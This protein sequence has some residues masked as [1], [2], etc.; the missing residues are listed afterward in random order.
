VENSSVNKKDVV[1]EI[2][3]GTGVIT[4]EL[5]NQ[6]KSVTAFEFDKNLYR[7]LSLKF[8]GEKNL[9]LIN[10]DFLAYSLPS[11]SYKVFSNIPFNLTSAIIK[12]LIF[13]ENSPADSYLIVQKEAAI[14]FVGKPYSK[15]NSQVAVLGKPWFEFNIIHRFNRADFSPRPSVDTVLLRIEKRGQP[16]L[17]HRLKEQYQDFVVYVFS[18]FKPN[19]VEGLSPL[20]NRKP[21]LQI[22]DRLSISTN[23]KPS[24][25]EYKGWLDIFEEFQKLSAIKKSK[26]KGSYEKL[27]NQ[28]SKIKI[29]HRTRNDKNWKEK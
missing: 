1:F 9:K 18:Q 23:T 4:E 10:K 5:V 29:I 15:Q 13:G 21:I 26:I 22:I 7:K 11:G 24:E 12:K 28:Q 17:E 27:L 14:R 16:H 6:S 8:K 19:I 20:F 3:A 2:G 25:L